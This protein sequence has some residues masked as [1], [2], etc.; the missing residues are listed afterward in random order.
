MVKATITVEIIWQTLTIPAYPK[1]LCTTQNATLNVII[2][3]YWNM[4]HADVLLQFVISLRQCIKTF[5][6]FW[7]L[8]DFFWVFPRRLNFVCQRFGTF[9][10]FHLH[11]RVS[12]KKRWHIKF[13]RRGITQ[14]ITYNNALKAF[15]NIGSCPKYKVNW[16][17]K[18]SS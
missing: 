13:R 15:S 17:T 8:Y 18:T 7:I 11:R 9:G 10:L 2:L 4:K 12:M 1:I 6:M 14:K 16:T 5:A 3:S